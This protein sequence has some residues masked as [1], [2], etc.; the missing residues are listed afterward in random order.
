MC[1]ILM[2][3]HQKKMESTTIYEDND[4]LFNWKD[5]IEIQ[6]IHS[7]ENWADLLQSSCEKF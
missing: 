1:D 7:C 6:K 2:V 3:Y 5:G 4:A